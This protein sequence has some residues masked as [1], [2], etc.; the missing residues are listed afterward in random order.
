MNYHDALSAATGWRTSK[1]CE[2]QNS[3]CHGELD[4]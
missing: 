1:R 4:R 3:A 2:A